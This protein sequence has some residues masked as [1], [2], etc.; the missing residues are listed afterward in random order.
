[1]ARGALQLPYISGPVPVKSNTALPCKGNNSIVKLFRRSGLK[2]NHQNYINKSNLRF[3][4]RYRKFDARA[5]IHK[6]F[7]E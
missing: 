5:I 4:N 2:E 1:M 3:I 6:I 7:G